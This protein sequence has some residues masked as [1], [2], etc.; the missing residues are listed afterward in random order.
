[1]FSY[2]Y[3]ILRLAIASTPTVLCTKKRA[4]LTEI[5][6]LSIQESHTKFGECS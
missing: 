1:M 2:I 3:V 5:F 4:E 6:L